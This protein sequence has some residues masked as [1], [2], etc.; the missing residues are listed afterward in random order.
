MTLVNGTH[1]PHSTGAFMC[2]YRTRPVLDG[3]VLA[4]GGSDVDDDDIDDN[5]SDNDDDSNDQ[6]MTMIM[7]KMMVRMIVMMV[8]TTLL[9]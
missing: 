5:D 7:M 4:Q 2:H 1:I 3:C 6:V 8:M 9:L